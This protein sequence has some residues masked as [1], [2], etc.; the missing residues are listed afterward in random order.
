MPQKKTQR[1]TRKEVARQAGVSTATI[2]YVINNGP[3]PVAAETR[4]RILRAIEQLGYYPNELARSL[5]RQQ[6]TTI[7]LVIPDLLNP[8]YASLARS[9]EKICFEHGYV[10]VV[11]STNRDMDKER[12]FAE[13]LRAKQVDGVVFL[14]DSA[15][16]EAIDILC[17]AHVPVVVLEHDVP[18]QHCITLNDLRGGMIGTGHL[19]DLGHRR[20]GFIQQEPNYTTSRRRLEGSFLALRQAGL[21][22]DPGLVVACESD[23]AAGAAAMDRLLAL[24][25]PPSAVFAHNDVIALGAMHAIQKAGLFVPG[26]I[27][28]MGYDDIASAAFFAPALTTISYPKDAMARSAAQHLL[29][30]IDPRCE[31]PEP[32]TEL[33]PVELVIR[34]S[35]ALAR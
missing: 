10:V 29:V 20:I 4:E 19:L 15:S 2:S 33:L 30:M 6:T 22:P 26:D 25:E 28:V 7:G 18:G 8:V 9:L 23:H 17:Q 35:T 14:P 32:T 16:L 34:Q 27:S 31:P 21:E 24:A 11:C 5:R 12:R 13:L 3:R 1:V